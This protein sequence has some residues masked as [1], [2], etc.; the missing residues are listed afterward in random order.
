M[1][2]LRRQRLGLTATT[3]T[4]ISC[5]R[6]NA[7]ALTI[8]PATLTMRR[9]GKPTYGSAN[10]TFPEASPASQ[11]RTQATATGGRWPYESGDGGEQ[12]RQPCHQ[13][14]G[15]TANNGNYNFV[16]ERAMP[17]R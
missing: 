1:S 17:P 11:W 5:K 3:A 16:Q 7:N 12:C 10:P 8:D 4:T 13:R 15:L 2:Q 14:L 6:G 9:T